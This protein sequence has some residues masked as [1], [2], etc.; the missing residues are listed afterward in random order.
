MIMGGQVELSTR[1]E[2]RMELVLRPCTVQSPPPG[3]VG[4]N[5]ALYWGKSVTGSEGRGSPSLR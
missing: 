5:P 3:L 1:K 2:S 4:W